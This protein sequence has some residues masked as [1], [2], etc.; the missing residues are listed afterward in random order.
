MFFCIIIV[1]I[2]HKNLFCGKKR[3]YFDNLCKKPKFLYLKNFIFLDLNYK[4]PQ[5]SDVKTF[6]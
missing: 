5:N 2:I 1:N 4:K 6:L 3:I